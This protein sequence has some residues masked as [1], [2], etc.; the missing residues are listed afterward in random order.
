MLT[1]PP[2]FCDCGSGQIQILKCCNLIGAARIRAVTIEQHLYTRD[3]RPT[4]TQLGFRPYHMLYLIKRTANKFTP[5]TRILLFKLR[6]LLSKIDDK[7]AG[8]IKSV[9]RYAGE[10]Y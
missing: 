7:F 9:N 4:H 8:N 2:L 3:T 5:H 6:N 10:S 1:L